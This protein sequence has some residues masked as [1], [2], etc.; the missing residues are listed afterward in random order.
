ML[1]DN[2][3]A[4]LIDLLTV[5]IKQQRRGLDRIAGDIRYKQ[6]VIE[7]AVTKAVVTRAQNEIAALESDAS[8][9]RAHI[10]TLE[11]ALKEVS[12]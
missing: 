1:S 4:I 7:R 11:E 8:K 5:E 12:A 6:G 10:A 9:I 3:K 2:T